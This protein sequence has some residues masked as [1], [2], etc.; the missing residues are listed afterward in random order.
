MPCDPFLMRVMLK[1]EVYASREQYMRLTEKPPQR[2]KVRNTLQKKNADANVE[3]VVSKQ[4]L[5]ACL[6]NCNRRCNVII[7]PMV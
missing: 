3:K 2:Q 6:V 5:K 1:K 7:I 4:V